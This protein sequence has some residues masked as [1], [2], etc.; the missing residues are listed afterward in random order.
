MEHQALVS[1]V[2]NGQ[3]RLLMPA[4]VAERVRVDVKTLARWAAAGWIECVYT[5][6]GHRRYPESAV[7]A[8]L[9]GQQPG[10]RPE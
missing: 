2:L 8:M 7:R 3:E 1:A 9:N 4:E 5:A 10:R 6:G